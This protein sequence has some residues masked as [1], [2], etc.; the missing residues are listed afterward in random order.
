MLQLSELS[1]TTCLGLN[2]L[3]QLCT[4]LRLLREESGHKSMVTSGM[5]KRHTDLDGPLFHR[6]GSKGDGGFCHLATVLNQTCIWRTPA[7]VQLSA[8]FPCSQKTPTQTAS[9]QWTSTVPP[10]PPL[11]R[12]TVRTMTLT[13]SPSGTMRG[14]LFTAPLK[15]CD[16]VDPNHEVWSSHNPFLWYQISIRVSVHLSS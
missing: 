11:T 13:S 3:P 16:P 2:N 9:C 10:T 1:Q 14:S 6:N 8:F 5:A 7:E 12:P 15:V 4:C